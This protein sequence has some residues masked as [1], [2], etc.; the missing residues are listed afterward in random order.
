MSEQCANIAETLHEVAT[1]FPTRVGLLKKRGSGYQRFTFGE[2]G[3]LTDLFAR[4][5]LQAGM[6][7]GDRVVLMV[8]P[9]V[10]FICMTFALFKIG[11]VVVLIDPGMGYGNLLQCIAKVKPVGFVAVAKA[12]LFKTFFPQPFR[13]VRKSICVGFS[14]GLFGPRLDSESV[15]WGQAG[16]D[17]FLLKT[18]DTAASDPAAILFTTGSTGPPK[19]VSYEH[20]TFTAQLRLIRD[21]YGI[22]ADDIDQPAFPLFGLFSAALGA[23]IVI[24]DMNPSQPAKVNPSSFIQSILDHKVTYSFGSPAIWR[25]VS[26]YCSEKGIR[27]TSLRKVL[28]AGA[29]VSGDLLEMTRNILP[30]EAQIYTPYGAT[31]AL[32]VSSITG[33]EILAETWT[34]TRSGKGVCVGRPLP[35]NT[36]RIIKTT[37]EILPDWR[38][39]FVLETGKIGEI[40]VKGPVVSSAYA[41]DRNATARAKIMDGNDFWHRM[42]D[43]GYFDDQNRLWFCG[44]KGHRVIADKTIY[45][46]VCCEA[47][48]NNHPSV[49]R[50]ALVGIGLPGKQVPVLIVEPL[51]KPK[52]PQRLLE[53]LRAV[54]KSHPLTASI[55]HFLL[56]PSFPVDIRH[57]AKIFR[58]KLAGW[59]SEKI[60]NKAP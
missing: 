42:G 29:P 39:D 36:I 57:N 15:S 3:N 27:L 6:Q 19:G 37:E 22:T 31:E 38:K 35:G 59:A 12:H 50:S 47:I 55:E 54:A 9:S 46:S 24:P 32:P 48:M 18:S 7:K 40:A 25:V 51:A 41:D 43:V 11:A 33:T 53:E 16:R 20:G 28:M 17:S 45:Y 13:T 21:Y 14:G 10:E 56:H 49:F 58:E 34:A 60:K 52:N 44:R 23:C 5:F 1:S 2:L 26:R 8:Q 30:P 4:A